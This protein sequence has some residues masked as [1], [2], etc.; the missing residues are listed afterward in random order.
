MWN[1]NW[2]NTIPNDM[3]TRLAE[4]RNKAMDIVAMAT[5]MHKYNP[6][7]TTESCFVRIL[8]WVGDW[9]GQFEITEQICNKYDWYLS[10]VK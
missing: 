8:D 9:N 5:E 1:D 4:C 6:N 7:K 3:L 10:R 2:R